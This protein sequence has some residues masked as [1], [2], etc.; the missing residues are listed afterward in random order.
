MILFCFC[1]VFECT[2]FPDKLT[3]SNKSKLFKLIKTDYSRGEDR[4]FATWYEL[5]HC[6]SNEDGLRLCC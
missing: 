5:N 6:P 4:D 1:A 3:S 2:F